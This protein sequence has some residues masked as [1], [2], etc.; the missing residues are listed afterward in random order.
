LNLLTEK[1]LYYIDSTVRIVG[2]NTGYRLDV[3]IRFIKLA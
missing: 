2:A 1:K 3:P